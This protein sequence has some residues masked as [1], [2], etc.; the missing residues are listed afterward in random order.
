MPNPPPRSHSPPH[1]PRI[2]EYLK[3]EIKIR[4]LYWYPSYFFFRIIACLCHNFCLWNNLFAKFWKGIPRETNLSLI[5]AKCPVTHSTTS[6]TL[7]LSWYLHKMAM[8]KIRRLVTIIRNLQI[9]KDKVKRA[10]KKFKLF[11]NTAAKRVEFP[12][13]VRFTAHNFNQVVAVCDM[14]LREVESSSTFCKQH[15]YKLRVSPA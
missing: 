4:I 2:L 10:I 6:R 12:C 11:W 14:L 3:E 9:K 5:S 1:P 7:S 15:L 8:I 13:C